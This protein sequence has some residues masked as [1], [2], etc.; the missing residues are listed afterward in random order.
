MQSTNRPAKPTDSN[1]FELLTQNPIAKELIDRAIEL[2]IAE[3]LGLSGVVDLTSDAIIADDSLTS[4]VVLL[5]EPGVIA[6]LDIFAL[7]MRR[8][9]PKINVEILIAEGSY[10]PDE[11]LPHK[12]REIIRLSG[13]SGKILAA[14]RLGLNLIQRMSGIATF[15]KQFVDKAKP[16]GISILDTRKTTPCLRVFEK[17]AVLCAGG[18]NH[19]MGL[20][21]NVLIKENHIRVAG[22]ISKAIDAVRKK[23]GT[24]SGKGQLIEVEVTNMAEVEEALAAGVEKV[25]LDNMTPEMV[26]EAIA[27]IQKKSK[28]EVSGGINQFNIDRYLIEGVDYISVGALTHSVKAIDLS[29]EVLEITSGTN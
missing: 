23:Y 8:F 22:G 7:V 12:P 4:A 3:D 28:I 24:G 13:P 19:R 1:Q 11:S 15:T 5:K 25:L 26:R 10:I 27:K 2:A 17:Y 18:T 21:D 20:Y 9:S 6:G 14:E 29:L 16:F